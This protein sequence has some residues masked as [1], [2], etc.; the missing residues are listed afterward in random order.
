MFKQV[1]GLERPMDDDDQD[2]WTVV[3]KKTKKIEKR[4][5]KKA[6]KAEEEKIAQTIE[7]NASL[8]ELEPELLESTT[9]VSKIKGSTYQSDFDEL[10]ARSEAAELASKAK[11][12]A[13]PK[14]KSNT[15]KKTKNTQAVASSITAKQT[16]QIFED[17][18]QRY[19]QNQDIQL[20]HVAGYFDKLFEEVPFEHADTSQWLSSDVQ[21]IV[22]VYLGRF[23]VEALEN[24]SLLLIEDLLAH[25][26]SCSVGNH[27]FF[28]LLINNFPTSLINHVENLLKNYRE[29]TNEGHVILPEYL[30]FFQEIVR[31]S[32]I[33]DAR[34]AAQYWLVFFSPLLGSANAPTA[35]EYLDLLEK[36]LKKSS[37]VSEELDSTVVLNSVELFVSFFHLSFSE[38]RKSVRAAMD[39]IRDSICQVL[40]FSDAIEC[41]KYF[42]VFLRHVTIQDSGEVK[43]ALLRLLCKSLSR[44]TQCF[45]L[46]RNHYFSNV[47]RVCALLEYIKDNWTSSE[48]LP[49]KTKSRGQ[50]QKE[51]MDLIDWLNETN[52]HLL[53]GT[54]RL[55]GQKDAISR[56]KLGVTKSNIQACQD[57]CSQLDV[58]FGRTAKQGLAVNKELES[59]KGS[60]SS[61]LFFLFVLVSGTAWAYYLG[62]SSYEDLLDLLWDQFKEM[63]FGS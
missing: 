41:T 13:K 54:Y 57:V 38:G 24:L 11:R 55:V 35:S 37:T 63:V 27:T 2:G 50:F 40:L 7:D 5:Q 17:A 45:G 31:R 8:D 47:T 44:N 18:F 43:P 3:N 21:D 4:L 56:K 22:S 36:T 52:Q 59:E 10:V 26:T 49:V 60:S 30:P 6:E 39:R 19:P 33:T 46:L 61:F 9:S 29:E 12:K 42:P 48:G 23:S 62:W 14:I 51:V 34:L 53:A 28:G 15:Q 20:R 32:A 25:P 58:V 16:R 1:K